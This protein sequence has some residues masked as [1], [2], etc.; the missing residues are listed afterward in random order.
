[1][2]ITVVKT[3][4]IGIIESKDNKFG[5]NKEKQL[6]IYIFFLHALYSIVL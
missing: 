1:M 4:G 3:A 6:D 2:G 5:K